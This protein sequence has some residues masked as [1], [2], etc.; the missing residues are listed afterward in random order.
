MIR[1]TFSLMI[2]AMPGW[3]ATITLLEEGTISLF[4][5]GRE[6]GPVFP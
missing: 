3:R 6:A 4:P 2:G 1:R 5:G